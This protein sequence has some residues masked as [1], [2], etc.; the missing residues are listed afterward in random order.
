MPHWV[1]DV[2]THS[3][4]SWDPVETDIEYSC[5]KVYLLINRTRI[6]TAAS[7]E[8]WIFDGETWNSGTLSDE[9]FGAEQNILGPSR[10][11]WTIGFNHVASSTWHVLLECINRGATPQAPRNGNLARNDEGV[12]PKEENLS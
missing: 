2:I 7:P 3:V 8:S 1:I 10:R 12:M 5:L 6:S 9:T 4:T 11:R